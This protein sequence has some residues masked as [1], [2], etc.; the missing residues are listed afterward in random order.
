MNTNNLKMRRAAMNNSMRALTQATPEQARADVGRFH[1]EEEN[2][3]ESTRL[4][5]EID[6]ALRGLRIAK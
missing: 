1:T 3:Y 4:L 5:N 2:V 6:D